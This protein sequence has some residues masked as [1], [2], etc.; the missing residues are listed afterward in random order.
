MVLSFRKNKER[1]VFDR[2]EYIRKKK[3]AFDFAQVDE[4]R[5]WSREW[6]G[7]VSDPGKKYFISTFDEIKGLGKKS[8]LLTSRAGKNL[9]I[10]V[11]SVTMNKPGKIKIF[12]QFL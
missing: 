11:K 2:R 3:L 9:E 4:A 8:G 1:R 12:F 7:D 5:Q 10:L 6:S